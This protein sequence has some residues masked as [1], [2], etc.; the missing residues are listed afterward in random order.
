[1]DGGRGTTHVR[2]GGRNKGNGRLAS[3]GAFRASSAFRA[4]VHVSPASRA[5]VAR[6]PLGYWESS[7]WERESHM[8]GAG[9]PLHME[10][11]Q[12]Y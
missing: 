9:N 2:P 4:T 5:G 11:L 10:S 12:R 8:A 3:R 6:L 1:M 7:Y